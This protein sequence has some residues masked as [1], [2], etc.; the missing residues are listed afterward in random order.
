MLWW[1]RGEEK[2]RGGDNIKRI[3]WRI[4][5]I[6]IKWKCDSFNAFLIKKQPVKQLWV[7]LA[8][9][10]GEEAMVVRK[11]TRSV[12]T[13]K[14]GKH[15]TMPFTRSRRDHDTTAES[16]TAKRSVD[17][18]KTQGLSR[19]HSCTLTHMHAQTHA[20][21]HTCTYGGPVHFPPPGGE[22]E[23]PSGR[24][25]AGPPQRDMLGKVQAGKRWRRR[26]GCKH[27][28]SEVMQDATC[29]VRAT[30]VQHVAQLF[31]QLWLFELEGKF[32]VNEHQ[33]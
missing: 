1:K 26:R 15:P 6:I 25:T 27:R 4:I 20:R 7:S 23:L 12:L 32:W 29:S 9:A 16:Q 3:Q 28:Q 11:G 18:I 14:G 30:Y 21:S 5:I 24:L 10:V 2:E 22:V 8:A 19:A 17:K 31:I 33:L 13:R